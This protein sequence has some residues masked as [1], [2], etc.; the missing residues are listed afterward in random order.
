MKVYSFRAVQ[1]AEVVAGKPGRPADVSE[2]IAPPYDVLDGEGKA[3]LL[4]RSQRNVVSIDL[5]HIPAKELGP[6]EAYDGA[7]ERYRG[8]LD[9]GTLVRRPAD[10]PAMFAYRETFVFTARTYRRTGMACAV[11][12]LPFGA[13]PGG[14]MLPHE[15]TFSGPKE[16]RFAL[17][18][19]TRAQLSPIFGL[20]AD[21]AGRATALVRRIMERAGPDLTATTGDGVRHEVWTVEDVETI[22]SY[23]AALAGEDVFIADGHHRYTTGLNYLKELESHGPVPPPPTTRPA[24]A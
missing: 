22:E 21:E 16:D 7:A 11:E 5:P 2:V 3:T 14:G 17:M 10:R 20:H 8:W 12:T 13:R 24:G 1:Y 15:E 18:K 9:D 19:A 23:R 4:R 6:R